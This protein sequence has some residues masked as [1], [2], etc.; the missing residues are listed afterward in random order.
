MLDSD[1]SRAPE[2][3]ETH[4]QSSKGY[5]KGSLALAALLDDP[6]DTLSLARRVF[7]LSLPSLRVPMRTIA[8][9]LP[10]Q[11]SWRLGSSDPSLRTRSPQRAKL[12]SL[13][14]HKIKATQ[15]KEWGLVVDVV[16]KADLMGAAV[17]IARGACER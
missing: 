4:V 17:K 12:V 8:A 14:G 2:S 5:K 6:P 3:F 1:V 11:C 16:P 9:T 7:P 13:C 10:I 15:A